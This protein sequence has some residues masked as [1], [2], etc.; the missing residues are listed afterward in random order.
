[1]KT[2]NMKYL[3]TAAMIFILVWMGKC[4]VW[5]AEW[6]GYDTMAVSTGE[7]YEK[8]SES[9]EEGLV[10]ADGNYV[11]ITEEEAYDEIIAL[12]DEYPEGRPWTNDDIYWSN[13]YIGNTH[14]GG[15]GCHGFALIV[16]D[17]VFGHNPTQVYTDYTQ[18]RVGDV[19]RI[20]NDTHTV[21]VLEDHLD[22]GYIVVTEGNYN[23]SIHWGRRISESSLE[24]GFVY[25]YTRYVED[26]RERV[27]AFVKR[28]YLNVLERNPDKAGLKDWVDS[29]IY[30]ERT[31]ADVAG[32]FFFSPEFID[33]RENELTNEQYVEILYRTMMDRNS[34]PSG[35][36][37]WLKSI[38]CGF[39]DMFILNGFVGSRE[40]GEICDEYG[41]ICG[42]LVLTEP[43]DQ[44]R[45]VTEFVSRN[46]TKALGRKVDIAG[47]ND[48]CYRILYEGLEP[49]ESVKGFVFSQEFT[50]HNY[51]N[52]EFVT[53]MYHTFFDREP[54]P[55][56]YADWVDSLKNNTRSRND[57]VE[58]FI[59]APEFK[60]LVASFGL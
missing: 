1:M 18:L 49:G 52:E 32:G 25:G 39:S 37:Y 22:E 21:V 50:E 51:S 56:G 57:V 36:E 8:E 48:W 54:D 26:N 4:A 40:F 46:Y 47:L 23:S 11:S 12:A 33:K 6:D 45:G 17:A 34:D 16:S 29:L 59:G 14:M 30:G 7:V 24:Q 35:R 2:R 20:N 3:F 53:I 5:A 9:G 41:I 19:L 31:G 10:W 28:L 38:D 42:R 43:R 58:G 13:I 15:A 44:S 60:E 27:R 55:A